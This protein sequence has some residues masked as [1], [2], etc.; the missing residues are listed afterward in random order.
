MTLIEPTTDKKTNKT[1]VA[2]PA[3]TVPT[4]PAKKAKKET[5]E[6]QV[7]TPAVTV[8][9]VPAKK[10]KKETKENQVDAPVAPTVTL[11]AKKSKKTK[12]PDFGTRGQLVRIDPGVI[13]KD[14]HCRCSY[15]MKSLGE[16][17]PAD[18]SYYSRL[19]RRK[20]YSPDEKGK[21]GHIAKTPLH[22]ARWAIQQYSKPGQWVLDPTIGAGTTAV[23]SITQGRS[24]AGMEIE[25]MH[26]VEANVEKAMVDADRSVDAEIGNG[27]ARNIGEFLDN[28]K[29]KKKFSLVVNNPPYSGDV[30]MP[31]P[32][33]KLRG[34]EHRHLETKFEYDKELPNLAFLKEGQIYWDTMRTIY[35]ECIKRLDTGGRFVIGVKD[36]MRNREPFLLHK[37]FCELLDGM[38]MEFE[39]TAFLKHYPSTLFL[40]TYEKFYGVVPPLYQTISVFKKPAG[41]KLPAAVQM[42]L[43]KHLQPQKREKKM[44]P[45]V[46]PQPL[47]PEKKVAKKTVVKKAAPVKK[48][49]AKKAAKKVVAKKG[50]K[51]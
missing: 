49:V 27:D 12:A 3:V 15:C 34:K 45:E 2:S 50:K 9:T 38:G 46:E 7:V 48:T 31:S 40:N 16:L 43:P 42:E 29:L 18:G 5:K 37:F 4:V 35:G 6:N 51:K 22:I 39:G 23:E 13:P 28:L 11:P 33:G 30:S 10:A 8:P 41:W 17:R 25:F 14:Y 21:G 1:K 36:M 19:D 32:K 20:Y 24:V 44:T 26:V 47:T